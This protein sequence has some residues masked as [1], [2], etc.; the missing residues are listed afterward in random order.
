MSDYSLPVNQPCGNQ[1]GRARA[2]IASTP[3]ASLIIAGRC[4]VLK[5]RPV[6]GCAK[7][8]EGSNRQ[9]GKPSQWTQQQWISRTGRRLA[10]RRRNKVIHGRSGTSPGAPSSQAL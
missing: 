4:C 9:R 8:P 2:L 6:A 10:A 1:V 3:S 7:N 5:V